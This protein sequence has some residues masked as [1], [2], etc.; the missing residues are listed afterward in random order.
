MWFISL[1]VEFMQYILNTFW[2]L[3]HI[4]GSNKGVRS[5]KSSL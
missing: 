2:H 4:L 1:L 3:L 5:G